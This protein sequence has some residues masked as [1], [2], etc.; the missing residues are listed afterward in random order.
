MSRSVSLMF[1]NSFPSFLWSFG[2]SYSTCALRFFILVSKVFFLQEYAI[3]LLRI[4]GCGI[5]ISDIHDKLFFL[6]LVT[7]VITSTCVGI[8]L[9]EFLL[10]FPFVLSF[11]M[12]LHVDDA[13]FFVD[14]REFSSG[15]N[16]IFIELFI[17]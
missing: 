9:G 15:V 6:A 17:L 14:W 13:L 3:Y 10:E 5:S 1:F 8:P 2:I 11:E 16:D 12:V 4:F 7:Y